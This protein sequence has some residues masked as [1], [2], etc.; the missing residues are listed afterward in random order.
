EWA[1]E[2]LIEQVLFRQVAENSPDPIDNEKVNEVFENMCSQSDS[3]EEFLQKAEATED[4]LRQ[5]II[6]G[7]KVERLRD[8]I[9]ASSQVP[10]DEEL[11]VYYDKNTEQFLQPELVHA[12]HIVLHSDPG[13]S[14]ESLKDKIDELHRQLQ[15]GTSFE[16][17][18]SQYSSCPDSGGDLGWFPRGQMVQ[19]FEEI[20]FGLEP[21][22]I[23]EP[24]ETEFGW[25]IAKVIDK[26][27]E[28]VISFENAREHIVEQLEEDLQQKALDNFIDAEKEKADIKR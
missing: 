25:H 12:A 19:S 6:S 3:K 10:T 13:V 4:Q 26:S 15:E 1:C 11:K 2:N 16:T 17:I 28:Q 14:P 23:S 21:G 7:L 24:F 8:Q 27:P 20:V 9:L 18:A 5:Q 22:V